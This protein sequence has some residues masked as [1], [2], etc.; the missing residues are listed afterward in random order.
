VSSLLHRLLAVRPAPAETTLPDGKVTDF[1]GT[2]DDDDALRRENAACD[3]LSAPCGLWACCDAPAE[4]AAEDPV[5]RRRIVVGEAGADPLLLL[6]VPVLM[7]EGVFG[8]NE[9][10]AHSHVN[11]DDEGPSAA[12]AVVDQ[13]VSLDEK[14]VTVAPTVLDSSCCCSWLFM[15]RAMTDDDS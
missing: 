10:A 11:G 12:T 13:S 9:E 7:P 2:V 8:N 5:V 14:L 6:R 15:R 4:S 1:R 3:M